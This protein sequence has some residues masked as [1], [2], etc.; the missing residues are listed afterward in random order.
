MQNNESDLFHLIKKYVEISPLPHYM[1][2]PNVFPQQSCMVGA[3]HFLAL[4]FPF[5]L[6][7]GPKDFWEEPEHW[8]LPA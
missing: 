6:T 4:H 8:S 2:F 1:A 7:K 5:T 3:H